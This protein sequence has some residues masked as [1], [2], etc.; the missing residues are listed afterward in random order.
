MSYLFWALVH[1]VGVFGFQYTGS[2][3]FLSA[4]VLHTLVN[5]FIFVFGVSA[6]LTPNFDVEKLDGDRHQDFG[7][8]FLMQIGMILTAVQLFMIGYE[9]FAGMAILQG[10]VLSLSVILQKVFDEE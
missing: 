9:F 8:R 1:V 5:M 4:G 6:A 3:W 2:I 10:V 7:N